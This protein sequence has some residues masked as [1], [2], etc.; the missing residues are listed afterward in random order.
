MRA[1]ARFRGCSSP[2]L[3][4]SLTRLVKINGE[5]RANGKKCILCKK[6]EIICPRGAIQVDKKNR[7]WYFTPSK[8][9]KCYNCTN[10]CPK[11]AIMIFP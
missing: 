7:K 9:I 1:R 4:K 3:L 2:S 5:I 10:I 8:C 6:C 11:N